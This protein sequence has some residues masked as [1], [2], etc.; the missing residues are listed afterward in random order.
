MAACLVCVHAFGHAQTCDLQLS[1]HI[2]GSNHQSLVGATIALAGSGNIFTT[3][4]HGDFFMRNLCADS[5]VLTVSFTGYETQTLRLLLSKTLHI[6][7][8]LKPVSQTL[9]AVQ[10]NAVRS[11]ATTGY[12]EELSGR[13]LQQT[14]G[15]SLAEALSKINGVTLLQ[16]GTNISKPVVHGLHSNRLLTI[17][18]GVRQ[19]G[20]QWGSEHAPEIDPFLASK[21]TV[22]KGVDELR[23][24]S[25]A[26]AGVVLVEPKAL[27]NS[28]GYNAEFNA[29]YFTNN[30]AYV[31]SAIF[32]QQFK[33]LPGFT[34][35]I[36][37]T[38]K[39]G[40]NTATPNYRLNNTGTREINY[41]ATAG[42]RKEHFNSELFYSHF[43]T[44]L[45]I[46][47]GSHIGN[48][49]D[50]KNAIASPV[51]DPVFTGQNTYA[52][53]RPYQQVAHDLVKSKT[54]FDIRNQKFT[55]QL[56]AQSDRR[57]E[58]DVVRSRTNVKP[59]I[60]L[61]IFT[62]AEELNWEHPAT[63][64]FKGL[65]GVTA[66]QQQNTYGGRYLIPNY[67]L[68]SFGAYC[69]E[70]YH[71]DKWNADAG[72][73][74]DDKTIHTRRLKATA[75]TF[76]TY[77]FHFTTA[78]ASL[79]GGYKINPRFSVNA[80][81]TYSSRS[82]QVNELLTN[83][84]HHG[85][86]TYEVGDINLKPE[87]SFNTVLGGSVT[88]LDA[89]FKA[90]LSV[91]NNR[92][93]GFIYEQPK[94]DEPVLTISGAFPKLQ[95]QST[96]ANLKGFDADVAYQFGD[97]LLTQTKYALL[98]ARNLNLQDW[99]IGM[100]GD[101]WT[102]GITWNFAAKE[103][104]KDSYASIEFEKHFKQTRVPSDKNGI[105]DYKTPPDAY[106]L[107]NAEVGTSFSIVKKSVTLSA[108][109]RNIFDV[110]YRD[111]LN[112]FRYFADETGR[113]ISIKLKFNLDHTN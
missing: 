105:Q 59:Q 43:F 40:A 56:S 58:Y 64:H 14:R 30:R 47:T 110:A 21:L 37:A 103:K 86:G 98:R 99:L 55:V 53:G 91:Y 78:A 52:I 79:N 54:G 6:D 48:L 35:R 89:K 61:Q 15:A 41:S 80:N 32:E 92:I 75:T 84:V 24:G 51:P 109:A 2:H 88:S 67:N 83:G 68:S 18:N 66:V 81:A 70:K 113:N 108:S 69:I 12:K 102:S 16:T 39:R 72:L 34:Y 46:F 111:Y 100:P 82:P 11:P 60:D 22:I 19:E 107:V 106:G 8:D 57:Q 71:K 90:N 10:V 94:P 87:H 17:N 45:G 97:H 1:G 20:Q 4:V 76:D 50:L 31:A 63:L 25:D 96:D 7:V 28:A 77:D 26:I 29:G 5:I 112:S 13:A 85:N 49:T 27:R 62:F 33:S 3:D 65:A 36:Q 9:S 95:Y 44:R 101:I 23:Y 104:L 42:Y 73:R 93:N 74:L 38:Y